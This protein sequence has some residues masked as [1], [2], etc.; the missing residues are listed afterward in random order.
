MINSGYLGA[1]A[2]VERDGHMIVI[3][4]RSSAVRV[5]QTDS[6]RDTRRDVASGKLDTS[7]L[8]LGDHFLSK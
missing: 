6:E 2:T 8:A 5:S 3:R 4:S 1:D 7:T